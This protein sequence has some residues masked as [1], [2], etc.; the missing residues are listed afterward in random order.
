MEKT[1]AMNK[2]AFA[3]REYV[4]AE[5]QFNKVAAV[6][7]QYAMEKNAQNILQRLGLQAAPVKSNMGRNAALAALLLGGLG[8]GAYGM[9]GGS[10]GGDMDAIQ[11]LLSLFGQGYNAA[12]SGANA[13]G[14]P[15]PVRQS[16]EGVGG[17]GEDL[18]SRI[19]GAMSGGMGSVGRAMNNITAP[20]VGAAKRGRDAL[21]QF[22][23]TLANS[24]VDEGLL[25]MQLDRL[26]NL[27]LK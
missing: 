8:A 12:K 16:M 3:V 10:S 25:R 15:L 22:R 7:Q 27:N 4:Q 20:M 21:D 17:F 6:A 18:I 11:T 23:D 13:P 19:T 26:Q 5:A 9:R 2:L 1:A 24:S 14:T